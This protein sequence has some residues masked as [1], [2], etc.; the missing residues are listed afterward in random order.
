MLH[1]GAQ[2]GSGCIAWMLVSPHYVGVLGRDGETGGSCA[3][4][5][6]WLS[7]LEL[8]C[9]GH[10]EVVSHVNNSHK[11]VAPHTNNTLYLGS[12]DSLPSTPS[13]PA[14]ESRV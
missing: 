3:G 9:R 13:N 7:C 12:W 5:G 11:E 10:K 14:W 2:S 4:E 6:A 1:G 8:L